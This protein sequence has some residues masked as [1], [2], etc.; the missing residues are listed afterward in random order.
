MNKQEKVLAEKVLKYLCIGAQIEGILFYG[1][2]ILISES[3]LSKNRILG[4][5]QLHIESN[6]CILDKMPD[7][8]PVLKDDIDDINWE[9]EYKKVLTLRLKTITD[10]CL[11]E[12]VPHLI[13][14][15]DNGQ[16]IF[17][18]GYH[19]KFESWQVE[20]LG[21]N[22]YKED[23]RVV[24]CPGGDIEVWTPKDIIAE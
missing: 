7:E 2:R 17:V 19:K 3:D 10:V 9:D 20:I 15:L 21:N 24:A 22:D 5:T 23:W 14:T 13:I 6:W 18:H 8:L 1:I 16:I 11:G 12:D 4:Q